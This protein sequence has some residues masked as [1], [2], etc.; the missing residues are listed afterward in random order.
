MPGEHQRADPAS[1]P[2]IDARHLQILSSRLVTGVFAGEYR[3]GFRG[4]GI[5]FEEVREYQPGDDIRSID[6]NVTARS[7]RPFVKLFAEEREMSVMILL[8]R[9]PSLARAAP[10]D[11]RSRVAAETC[12]LLIYAAMRSNDR[13]G[14]LTFTDAV[15]RYVA[16][17]KGSRH[18]QR[19]VGELLR[20]PRGQGTDLAAAL[21]HVERV[22]RQSSILF[23][24]SDFLAADFSLP[25]AAAARRHD[26]VA[27][28]VTD[29]IDRRLPGTDI[30]HLADAETGRRR[31]VDAANAKVRAAYRRHD[32]RRRAD[33]AQSLAAAG[34]AHLA[35]ATDT[36]PI[37]ALARF[38]LGRQ[39]PRRR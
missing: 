15:E 34:V 28:S 20:P 8:D 30:L 22:H 27:V 32:A 19:L 16:P 2:N 18:A 33:L 3:S 31:L 11:A 26:V 25:L 7:G 5:E 9:S 38:F 13:V 24:V 12:A 23:V 35:V 37:R 21:N 1:S 17:A 4:P 14:L 10:R 36:P 39:R 6:W 29:P